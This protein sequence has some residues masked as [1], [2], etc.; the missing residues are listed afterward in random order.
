MYL[1]MFLLSG[2]FLCCG[3]AVQAQPADEF[4]LDKEY[5][6]DAGGM[7]LLD[8]DDAEVTVV[9]S[10]RNKVHVVVHY[11]LTSSGLSFGSR[12]PFEME[13]RREDGN[14]IIQELP[15][16]GD[17]VI[18]GDTDKEY[19]I[20]IETPRGVDLEF[21]GDD[22]HYEIKGINGRISIDADDS[23]ISLI[24]CKGQWFAFNLDDGNLTMDQGSGTLKLDMD[25]GQATIRHG[26]FKSIDLV[27]DDGTVEIYTALA[28][29][30]DY[31]FDLDDGNLQLF[32]TEGGGTFTIRHDNS[33][34]QTG[35]GFELV[36]EQGHQSKYELPGGSATVQMQ[37]DDT[38]VSL[39]QAG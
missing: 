23:R 5:S 19:T 2:L 34:I 38:E 39:Q 26:T 25:D 9:G 21:K 20:R 16:E 12:E 15:R 14:L 6:I 37:A 17:Q 10:D 7:I 36:T 11:K 32:I 24:D 13:V 33:S 30:G 22:E 18:I 3:A 31:S 35:V 27:S 1:K 8:S 4:N 29:K 28:A